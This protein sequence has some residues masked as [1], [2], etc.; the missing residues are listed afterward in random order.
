MAVGFADMVAFT[1]MSRE[2]D[3]MDLA[4]VV[5]RF[6]ELWFVDGANDFRIVP[7]YFL[8]ALQELHIGFT[9]RA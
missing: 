6:E 9:A 8:R 5:E 4:R 1:Q 3:E 2:L 7:Q